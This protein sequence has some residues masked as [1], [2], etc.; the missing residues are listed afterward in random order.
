MIKRLFLSLFIIFC[1]AS[2]EAGKDKLDV[3]PMNV[4]FIGNSYTRMNKMPKIFEKIAQSRGVDINV[5]MSA[6]SSHT[7]NMHSKREA[8][9][10]TIKS[11]KWDFVVLQGFSRELSES[12]SYIDT[13]SVPYIGI[14]LDSIYNNNPCT[15]VLLYMTWGYKNGYSE[16]EE[17]ST[18]E[19]MSD[20]IRVGYE[21]ISDLF[22]LPIVP[23]GP[24][25]RDFRASNNEIELYYT[26]L[27]HP[28]SYGSYMIACSFYSA[29]FKELPE[30]AYTGSIGNDEAK[31]L[32]T[33]AYNYVMNNVDTFKLNQ[34]MITVSFERTKMGKYYATC[35]ANYPNAES[36]TWD[37]GDGLSS[38]SSDINHEYSKAGEYWVTLTI[39]D[40]CGIR[41]TK[42]KVIFEKPKR[43]S[44]K[45]KSKAKITMDPVKKV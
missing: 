21:Y 39:E 7:F 33:S 42:R 5:E 20:S 22:N 2:A 6:E 12:R 26:D 30:D 31:L 4:L 29:I 24:V 41:K 44:R 45:R 43:P 28:S 18:N 19:R 40:S 17:V 1:A 34:N 10:E 3:G 37:F 13:A 32:Q 9:F 23:V 35:K 25:W 15:N 11:E 8:M 16:R 36:V 14:I 27:A 38:K